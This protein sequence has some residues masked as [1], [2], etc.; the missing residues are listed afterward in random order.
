MDK[1]LYKVEEGK[2]LCGVCTGLGRYLSIDPTI[3][4]LLLV[5]TNIF[6]GV[7]TLCYILAAIILPTED[8]VY[9]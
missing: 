3:I 4:R 1:K 5:C 8:K 6:Y 2:M 9:K 7:G